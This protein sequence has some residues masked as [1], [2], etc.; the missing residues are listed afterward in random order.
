M[1]YGIIGGTFDPPHLGHLHVAEAAMESL[2]LDEVI[3]IPVFRNPLKSMVA[4]GAQKR[5]HM[6]KLAITGEPNMS[7]SDVETTRKGYSYLTDTLKE[8]KQVLPGDY[9]F[10]G[11]ADA[12]A[13]IKDWKEP[14]SIFRQCRIALVSRPGTDLE[15]T[16]SRLGKEVTRHI[17]IVETSQMAVSSSNIR[18]MVY[19]GEDVAHHLA[20]AVHDYI[21]KTG[22]YSNQK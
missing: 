9:W 12:I 21:V 2:S 15:S 20:P 8:L 1:K 17:D 5:L 18:D 16:L 7:V 13:R 19:K 6:C 11:G 10:I 22:L 3:W 4:T 14:E